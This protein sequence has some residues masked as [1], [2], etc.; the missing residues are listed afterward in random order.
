MLE[1]VASSTL[2]IVPKIP[3]VRGP[4]LLCVCMRTKSRRP[5]QFSLLNLSLFSAH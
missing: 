4:P 5:L 2:G 3:A 1:G